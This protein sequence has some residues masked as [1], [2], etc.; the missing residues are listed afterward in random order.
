[1]F[2]FE[3]ARRRYFRSVII[4]VCAAGWIAVHERYRLF[5]YRHGGGSPVPAKTARLL[6]G[7]PEPRRKCFASRTQFEPKLS[8]CERLLDGS[9]ECVC[10][11]CLCSGSLGTDSFL[12]VLLWVHAAAIIALREQSSFPVEAQL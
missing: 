10:N 11:N 9:A 5:P 3:V 6:P 7:S 2:R 8:Q 1:M 4:V 12:G